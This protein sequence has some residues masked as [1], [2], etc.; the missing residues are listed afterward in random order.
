MKLSLMQKTNLPILILGETGTGKSCLAKSIAKYSSLFLPLNIASLNPN[1]FESEL[2]GH[3]KGAFSGAQI[4]REGFCERVGNG[5]LFIDEI[6]ELSLAMQ[7]KLLTLI[8]E[9]IFYRVGCS[10]PRKFK[11]R[12]IFATNKDLFEMVRKGEFR[13]DLY[14]RLRLIEKKLKP[15]REMDNLFQIILD[16]INNMKLKYDENIIFD[17]YTL[18]ILESYDWPGNFRE[19]NNTI[20]VLFFLGKERIVASDLPTWVRE[21]KIVSKKQNI[22]V[23]KN[24][25]SY[26]ES[27]EEFEELFFRK[28]LERNDGRINQSAQVCGISKVTLISKLKKY[29]INRLHFKKRSIGS[30]NTIAG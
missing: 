5:V 8:D 11:G 24:S 16:I 4:T 30:Q 17:E 10:I 14:Y 18:S 13:E 29:D 20:E 3:V 23:A 28:L 25:Y 7:T 2:F 26:Q 22:N 15:L 19:L 1:I 27:M 9:R 12:L 21:K 6:G